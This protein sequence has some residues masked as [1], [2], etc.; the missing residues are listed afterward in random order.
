MQKNRTLAMDILRKEKRRTALWFTAFIVAFAVVIIARIIGK[1]GKTEYNKKLNNR[2]IRDA[3]KRGFFKRL[4]DRPSK[5]ELE[6]LVKYYKEKTVAMS[7][8]EAMELLDSPERWHYLMLL[9]IA[10]YTPFGITKAI[11]YAFKMGYLYAKE[12]IDLGKPDYYADAAYWVQEYRERTAKILAKTENADIL[13][14]IYYF[15]K[16]A[17]K[18]GAENEQ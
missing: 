4:A 18:A 1:D 5:A 16:R 11:I 12:K 13:A 7:D 14:Q 2:K 15:A 9:K 3:K 10:D 8:D 17:G 6:S